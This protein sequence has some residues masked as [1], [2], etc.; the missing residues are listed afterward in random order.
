MR[1]V[2]LLGSYWIADAIIGVLHEPYFWVKILFV[3]AVAM[4]ILELYSKFRKRS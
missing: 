1:F 4:D 2:I 3:V